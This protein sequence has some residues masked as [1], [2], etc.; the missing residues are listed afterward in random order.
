[1]E[2]QKNNTPVKSVK[3]AL[4]LLNILL[5]EDME[6]HGVSL[7]ELAKRMS[8]PANTAHN[9]LKTM[10]ACRYVAQLTDGR[11]IAGPLC[12]E[13]GKLNMLRSSEASELLATTLSDMNSK[14]DEAVVFAALIDGQRIVLEGLNANHVVRVDDVLLISHN[15]I[16]T[17][18]TGRVLVAFASAEEQARILSRHGL[19]GALWDDIDSEQRLTASLDGIRSDGMCVLTSNQ[20]EIVAFACPVC[21]TAGKLLGALGCFAPIFRCPESKQKNIVAEMLRVAEAMGNTLASLHGA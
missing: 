9:L 4:S 11:Y 5:F 17:T 12:G 8:M 15:N 10:A 20:N 3:K 2:T 6:R 7:S 16:Y 21:D 13:I 19:P 1:M 18:P 14:I